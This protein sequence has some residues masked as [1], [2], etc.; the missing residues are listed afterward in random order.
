[1]LDDRSHGPAVRVPPPLL[2]LLPMAMGFIAQYFVPIGIVTGVRP[3]HMLRLVGCAEILIGAALNVWA[4]RTFH[5]LH[6]TVL[7]H[8]P[9]RALAAEGPYKLTRNP[10]YLGFAIIYLGIAFVANAFW[11][12]LF[13]PEAIA[14]VSLFVIGREESYLRREFGSE[15]DDYRARVRR[16]L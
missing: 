15:Y 3:A 16:W 7:P 6:T 8:R 10:M 14:F 9:A 5:R 1:M 2:Y 11:V 12:L 4:L 13:L